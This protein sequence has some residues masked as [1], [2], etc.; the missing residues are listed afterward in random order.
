MIGCLSYLG[1]QKKYPD[2]KRPY[3]APLGKVGCYV[4]FV[5]YIFMLF[6]ADTAALLT[7]GIITVVCIVYW[8]LYTRRHEKPI[9]SIEEEIGELEEPTEE[10]KKKLDR[11]YKIWRNATAVVTVIALGIYLIPVIVNAIK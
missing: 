8:A 5:C 11:E 2:M 4:T 9:A 7:A 1:L 3:K 6:F 10:E